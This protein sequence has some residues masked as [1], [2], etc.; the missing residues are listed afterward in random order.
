MQNGFFEDCTGE[1]ELIAAFPVT[2][3]VSALVFQICGFAINYLPSTGN[4]DN[5]PSALTV[6]WKKLQII[7]I[8]KT[9][10]HKT[11]KSDSPAG[12]HIRASGFRPQPIS[13]TDAG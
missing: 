12:H 11:P 2:A 3:G 1:L 6:R 8:W 13:T 5:F 9:I 4:I 10:L 7:P